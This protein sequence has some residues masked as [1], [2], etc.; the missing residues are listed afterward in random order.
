MDFSFN[1]WLF[2]LNLLSEVAGDGFVMLILMFGR[3]GVAGVLIRPTELKSDA[4][5]GDIVLAGEIIRPGDI[6][7]AGDRFL[8]LLIRLGI[9]APV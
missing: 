3:S 5:N 9:R 1:L 6:D 2:N 8:G 7:R 4:A